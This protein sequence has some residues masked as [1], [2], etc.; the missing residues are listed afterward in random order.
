MRWIRRQE[1]LHNYSFE[2]VGTI[3]KQD[4]KYIYVLCRGNTVLKVKELQVS[5]KKRMPVINFLSNKK[6]YVG[7]ILGEINE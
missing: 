4:K 5:G 2:K 7:S 3:I 1:H 6:D